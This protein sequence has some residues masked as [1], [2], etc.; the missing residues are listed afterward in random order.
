MSQI[1][2]TEKKILSYLQKYGNT[3]ES[4]LLDFATAKLDCSPED[5]KKALNCLIV[6]GKIHHIVHNK[7]E[8]PQAYISLVEPW[9][10]ES[11]GDF[12]EAGVPEDLTKEAEAIL[13]EAAKLAEKRFRRIS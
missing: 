10:P 6:K 9:L 1:V 4:D 3:K 7:L 8:P 2:D 11:M 5:I 13:Q 12:M